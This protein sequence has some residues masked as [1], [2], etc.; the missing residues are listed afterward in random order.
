MSVSSQS[1]PIAVCGS[2][3]EYFSTPVQEALA[4]QEVPTSDASKTYLVELLSGFAKPNEDTASTFSQPITFLLRDAM[5]AV[6]PER[7]RRL[8]NLGDGVL[9]ALGFFGD[10]LRGV[11]PEY[12]A[13]VGASAYDHAARM[14]RTGQP[15]TR[16]PDLFDELARGFGRFVGVLRYVADWIFAKSARDEASL[17]RLYERWLRTGSTV[18]ESELGSRGLHLHSGFDGVH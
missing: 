7:F 12:I 17:V 18:I 4:S 5:Q 10:H 2:L 15:A 11:D 9:Y 13:R 1:A 16:G 8:Q 14:L 3:G 6:G